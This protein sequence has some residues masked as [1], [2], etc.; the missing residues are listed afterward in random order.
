[1]RFVVPLRSAAFAALLVLPA[2]TLSANAAEGPGWG[3]GH[4]MMWGGPTRNWF[5]WGPSEHFCGKEGERNI[6]RF[7]ALIERQVKITDAQKPALETLKSA[8]QSA[9]TQL[10]SLCEK[11]H[12]GRWS[13]MERLT[14]A[15][16][17][18]NAM[19]VAIKSIRGPLE[20]FYASLDDTQKKLFDDLRPDWRM[21]LPWGQ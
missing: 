16:A 12:S 17:H 4:A 8:F 2:L 7:S 3:P 9:M 10:D 13:P 21:R 15:E 18:L 5:G 11:P 6:E 19:L 20:A 1:M 14:A